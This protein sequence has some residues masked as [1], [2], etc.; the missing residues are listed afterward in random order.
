MNLAAATERMA[1]MNVIYDLEKLRRPLKNPVLTIGNFDGVHRGHLALF[2][3]VKERAKAL[4]GQSAVITFEP[5][6]VQ[7]MK[8]STGPR[9]I[10]PTPQKLE[11]IEKAGIEVLLCLPFTREFAA[12][13]ARDFVKVILVDRIGIKELVVG[14]DYTFGHKREGNL[15]LLRE[16][17]DQLGFVVHLVGPVHVNH[18]LVSSTS[19]RDLVQDGKLDEAKVLLGRDYQLQ[20]TVVRGHN[21]GGRLLGFPTANLQIKDELLP[22]VGVY[23]VS[24]VIEGRIY[25]GVTNVGYNPTFGDTPLTVETHI[26]DFSGDLPGRSIRVNFLKRLREEKTFRSVEDLSEQISKDIREAKKHFSLIEE[27]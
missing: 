15:S 25:N 13:G 2:E 12:I 17:G 22:K 18:A 24:V 23:A 21:R 16:M 20:G 6:P 3:Q 27:K 1:S 9:I 14:Y 5:H 19:I 8:T 7:V 26:L 10:T 4:H 11:L